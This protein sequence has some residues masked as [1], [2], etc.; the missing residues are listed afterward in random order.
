MKNQEPL[1]TDIRI[2]PIV[3]FVSEW[4]GLSPRELVAKTRK[5]EIVEPRQFVHWLAVNYTRMSKASIGANVGGV[6]HA[7]TLHSKRKIDNLLE[8]DKAFS[9]NFNEM[10]S[11]FKEKVLPRVITYVAKDDYEL[12]LFHAKTLQEK[13]DAIKREYEKRLVGIYMHSLKS[14]K[15]VEKHVTEDNVM[16]GFRKRQVSE[17]LS[18]SV[19][20][21]RDYKMLTL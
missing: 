8:V 14:L 15:A 1:Q 16:E 20:K 21:L 12:G 17:L 4:Y 11:A 10:Y 7:T 9:K 6:D 3:D 5:K 13:T 2:K 19:T 18:K